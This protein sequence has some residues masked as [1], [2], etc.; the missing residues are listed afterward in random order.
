MGAPYLGKQKLWWCDH[1]GLPLVS[2]RCGCGSRGKRISLTPPADVRPA[3]SFDVERVNSLSVSQF[4]RR[5]V[6]NIALLNKL[7]SKDAAY[8]VVSEGAVLARLFFDGEWTLKPTVA[9]AA[10]LEGKKTVIVE[11]EVF[12]FLERGDLLGPGVE[13]CSEDVRKGDEVIVASEN[14]LGVGTAR[15]GWQ[16][17]E[18]GERG[19]AVKMR[20]V[21]ERGEAEREPKRSWDDA[22]EANRKAIEK[23]VGRARGFLEKEIKKRDL[24]L[25]LAFSGGKDS[26]AALLL[27]R[28]FDPTVVFVD[29]GLEFPETVEEAERVADIVAKA[30]DLYDYMDDFG[31]PAR[32]FRWCCKICK[33]GPTARM[34][35]ENFPDGCLTIGGERRYESL[36]R[37]RRGRVDRNPW[38]PK[39]LSVYP[40]LDWTALE[41]WLY[42]FSEGADYNPLYEEGFDR[43]GCYL[44]PASDVAALERVREL[45]PELMERFERFLRE[46]AEEKGLG[47]EFLEGGW[48]AAAGERGINFGIESISPCEEGFEGRFSGP[49]DIERMKNLM[50]MIGGPESGKA[51]VFP[52]GRFTVKERKMAGTLEKLARRANLCTGCGLCVP[53]C[54]EGALELVDG[55]VRVIGDC[56]G[57]L[58]CLHHCPLGMER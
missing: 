20:E 13:S 46:Y 14:F 2:K 32:D 22:V 4:G 29:T 15:K 5:L 26:L 44:C 23:N 10:Y 39:Q 41:V 36:S 37:A 30:D 52:D 33:L 55:K 56:K 35:E 24:P 7:P 48:R 31:P 1:C 3:F 50:K 43:I 12:R 25:T 54:P 47:R 21:G 49:V 17:M 18:A 53:R 57:C 9:G 40:I 16:G 28:K 51:K 45:H 11:N 42:L 27:S 58:S 34:M 38:L 8:E 6:E 19:I